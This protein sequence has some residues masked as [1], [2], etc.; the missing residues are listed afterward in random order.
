M[1][2]LKSALA[3][4]G[5]LAI[6]G[7]VGGKQGEELLQ[8]AKDTATVA[9]EAIVRRL[10]QTT[11]IES[12][13][14]TKVG[15]GQG[16][17]K[18]DKNRPVGATDFNAQYGEY[19]ACAM[20][21]NEGKKIYLT[22][23]Q[24]YE[25][26]YTEKILDTLK[27]KNVKATFFVVGDY[28]KRNEALV[29]RMIDEGHTIGNHSMSHYSMPTLSKAECEQEIGSLHDYVLDKFGYEMTLFR[30][31]MGEFSEYSLAVT[32]NCGYETMLWSF[33]YYDW[34]TDDQ[35]DPA[36]AKEK[37]VSS[38]HDGAIYLLH[39]VSATNAEIL[40]DVIDEL[41][42]QGYEFEAR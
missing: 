15:Y 11:D 24:G 12:L 39:S 9:G 41:R 35:P 8:K 19:N 33:A 29:R 32:Q 20:K 36:G 28:V 34:V 21:E 38:A 27:E 26:G 13:D 16:V 25:N 1:K 30:P 4:V 2:I 6:I 37:L 18:D 42:A 22:F 3:L 14:R 10:S 31:P 23:D 5:A 7:S 17:I 40:G